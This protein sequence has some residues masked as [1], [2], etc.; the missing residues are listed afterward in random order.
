L[1][2]GFQLL[3]D[4]AIVEIMEPNPK[5]ITILMQLD[6]R[7]GINFNT[8]SKKIPQWK[9][10]IKRY[11]VKYGVDRGYIIKMSITQKLL[12]GAH[13]LYKLSPAGKLYM[14]EYF[15][16]KY[17]GAVKVVLFHNDSILL[18]I[19][20][21]E[22]SFKLSEYDLPGG[23]ILFG[24]SAREALLRE[25]KEETNLEAEI[26]CPVRTWRVIKEK[27]VHYIGTTFFAK[28]DSKN[29]RLSEEH[30]DFKWVII[31]N[32][33]RLDLAEWLE[34]DIKAGIET[35]QLRQTPLD[36]E[37]EV[38]P[39]TFD[40]QGFLENISEDIKDAISEEYN[41]DEKLSELRKIIEK[42][43]ESYFK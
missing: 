35:F 24:E 4:L 23:G 3:K 12:G 11:W 32:I 36:S 33:E 5:I 17:Q 18:L 15:G 38:K 40:T 8:L 31:R 43:L 29:V 25:I 6:L 34:K 22:N 2:N 1:K 14:Q 27:S 42:E 9:V 41:L 19:R 37:P 30:R 13:H 16:E 20:D 26:I 39:I 10:G 28:T 21:E 7:I